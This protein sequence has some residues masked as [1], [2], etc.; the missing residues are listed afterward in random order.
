MAWTCFTEGA[1]VTTKVWSAGCVSTHHEAATDAV[2][3]LPIPCP[4]CTAVRRLSRIDR[5]ISFCLDH[6]L[7]FAFLDAQSTGSSGLTCASRRLSPY[8]QLSNDCFRGIHALQFVRHLCFMTRGQVSLS[9]EPLQKDTPCLV[10]SVSIEAEIFYG[11]HCQ[12][13][14]EFCLSATKRDYLFLKGHLGSTFSKLGNLCLCPFVG[15]DF[16]N[17]TD[18][19]IPSHKPPLRGINAIEHLLT[20]F[21]PTL[22]FCQ[23]FRHLLQ[24]CLV[25][26]LEWCFST[27]IDFIFKILIGEK[28]TGIDNLAFVLESASCRQVR[29]AHTETDNWRTRAPSSNI[30]LTWRDHY[31][32]FCV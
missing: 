25:I 27:P 30:V 15:S 26:V 12:S 32:T 17:R 3:D 24:C 10:E 28:L 8:S 2:S 29:N 11:A 7:I 9:A 19:T 14:D 21:L 6:R 5:M 20:M 13:D 18:S 4:L 16:R 23:S 1:V 22:S 31:P